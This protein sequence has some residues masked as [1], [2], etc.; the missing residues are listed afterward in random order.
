MRRFF[1]L[2]CVLLASSTLAAD[3]VFKCTDS[4]GRTV[5]S[6]KECGPVAEKIEFSHS[7]SYYEKTMRESAERK[8]KYA[9]LEKK[10]AADKLVTDKAVAEMRRK[11]DEIC[12]SRRD[13]VGLS[14]GMPKASILEHDLWGYPDDTS[15]TTSA[16]GVKEYLVYKC[17]GY[18]PIR[19]FV[20]NGRLTSIHN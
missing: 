4:S 5:F 9:E 7:E 13:Q 1:I 6:D 12:S 16:Q 8:Q 11:H 17:D 15:K 10:L 18:P 3:T 14:I 19:M 20:T 2:A